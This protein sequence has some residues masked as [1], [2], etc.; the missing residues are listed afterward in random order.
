MLKKLS[1]SLYLGLI[2]GIVAFGFLGVIVAAYNMGRESARSVAPVAETISIS[3]KDRAFLADYVKRYAR[4]PHE[5]IFQDCLDRVPKDDEIGDTYPLQ[6]RMRFAKSAYDWSYIEME[7]DVATDK[8]WFEVAFAQWIHESPFAYL[9]G[10]PG[11]H[12]KLLTFALWPEED[13]YKPGTDGRIEWLVTP[14][15]EFGR[16]TLTL[17]FRCLR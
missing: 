2:L 13:K 16:K 12:G 14:K 3:E 5:T 9:R 4:D 7:T 11:E 17:Q 10:K 1:D 15:V 6:R 8:K